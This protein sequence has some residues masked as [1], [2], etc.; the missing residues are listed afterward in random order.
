MSAR[1]FVHRLQEI[2]VQTDL[3]LSS[4]QHHSRSAMA[5]LLRPHKRDVAFAAFEREMRTDP[6]WVF[7][8]L[9]QPA[10]SVFWKPFRLLVAA[11][12]GYSARRTYLEVHGD[13]TD[14]R[15]I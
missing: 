12:E 4:K 9:R 3:L 7:I 6:S 2:P 8:S 1:M 10:L 11:I 13:S 14:T 5:T 15:L